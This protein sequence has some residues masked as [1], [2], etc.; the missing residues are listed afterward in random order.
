M[1][2]TSVQCHITKTSDK[3]RTRDSLSAGVFERPDGWQGL[4]LEAGPAMP[5]R[6]E[7][8]TLRPVVRRPAGRRGQR[9][10]RRQQL[11]QREHCARPV[12]HHL[13]VRART[14][15]ASAGDAGCFHARPALPHL[16]VCPVAG[17]LAPVHDAHMGAKTALGPPRH[18]WDTLYRTQPFASILLM[19]CL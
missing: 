8:L 18:Y 15:F 6:R 1:H 10:V 13:R 17:K 2:Y 16:A 9:G 5:K 14:G 19:T 7:H 12:R 3:T 11:Q 4:L